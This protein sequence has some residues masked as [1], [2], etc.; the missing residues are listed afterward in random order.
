M[1]D[2]YGNLLSD[3]QLDAMKDYYF[4]DFSLSEI[5]NNT[6]VSKQAVS[7]LIKRAE[8]RLIEI[9]D[10]LGLVNRFSENKERID[11]ILT[12]L[13]KKGLDIDLINLKDELSE[14]RKNI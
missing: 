2:Y 8:A 13:D 3:K 12:C 14:L 9:E 4:S 11:R 6:G 1:L 7:D 10:E 5:A